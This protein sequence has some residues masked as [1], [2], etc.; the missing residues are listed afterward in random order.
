MKA[1]SLD[2]RER[3][4]AACAEP[5]ARIYQVAAR[6]SVSISFLDKLL[7]RQ[8]TS[9]SLAAFPARGGIEPRLDP[10]G[11]VQLEACLVQQPDATLCELRATLEGLGG[12]ALSRSAMGRA[13][14][15]LGWNRKKKRPCGRARHRARGSLAALVFG[16]SSA[17]GFYALRV[18]G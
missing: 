1:Y 10:S 8:R 13:V 16:G 12:P 5:N 18:R 3:I 2:L 9:G 4:A 17:R 15:G 7:H 11:R 14:I 6:F